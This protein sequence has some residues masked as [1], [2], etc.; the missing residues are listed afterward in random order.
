MNV[1]T[2]FDAGHFCEDEGFFGRDR[3]VASLPISSNSRL[4]SK[5]FFIPL[6]F[7]A[8]LCPPIEYSLSSPSTVV[9]IFLTDHLKIILLVIFSIVGRISLLLMR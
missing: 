4:I 2:F 7:V 1:D 3:M 5:P 6:S 8:A 9:S